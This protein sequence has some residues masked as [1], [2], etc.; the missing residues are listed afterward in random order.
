M[1]YTRSPSPN[2]SMPS[3]PSPKSQ[4]KSSVLRKSGTFPSKHCIASAIPQKNSSSKS[5]SAL[6]SPRAFFEHKEN[7]RD[8]NDSKPARTRSPAENPYKGIKG[9]MAPTISASSKIAAAA[10]RKKIL[11]EKNDDSVKIP[12]VLVEGV[13]VEEILPKSGMGFESE[14]IS[15]RNGSRMMDFS[16]SRGHNQST[17]SHH[18]SSVLV[19]E[20]K[21]E[22]ILPKS[23]MDFES[24]DISDQNRSKMIDFS[25][26]TG[27]NQSTG[28]HHPSCC[29]SDAD[30]SLPPYDP[31][32]NYLSPRPQFLHYKPKPMIEQN[33]GF[34]EDLFYV[35]DGRRLEDSFSDTEGSDVCSEYT[36]ETKASPVNM[37]P[38]DEDVSTK[39]NTQEAL[40]PYE[41]YASE[42]KTR[43]ETYKPRIYNRSFRKSKIIPFLL[44]ST[45]VLSCLPLADLPIFSPLMK[46]ESFVGPHT[47]AFGVIKNV[48]PK[49]YVAFVNR[50][51]QGLVSML[52]QWLLDFINVLSSSG[53][54]SRDESDMMFFFNMS[55]SPSIVQNV[56]LDFGYSSELETVRKK[57]TV[58][59]RNY[60]VNTMESEFELDK[61]VRNALVRND[62][63]D[64]E[65]LHF[66]LSDVN[67][68]GTRDKM[69]QEQEDYKYAKYEDLN[70][71][72]DLNSQ[73]K[74]IDVAI[75]EEA[76][77]KGYPAGFEIVQVLEE[78][79][80]V[81]LKQEN[82]HSFIDGKIKVGLPELNGAGAGDEM[83][84]KGEEDYHPKYE[85]GFSSFMVQ[86]K[87]IDIAISKEVHGDDY[88]MQFEE[89]ALMGL[90][91]E[92]I[93]LINKDHVDSSTELVVASQM[94][95]QKDDAGVVNF[96]SEVQPSVFA[97]ANLILPVLGVLAAVVLA[98]ALVFLLMK[99]KHLHATSSKKHL[100]K[101]NRSVSG[102]SVSCKD[103]TNESPYH[104]LT[105]LAEVVGD[106][107]PTEMSSCLNSSF[108]VRHQRKKIASHEVTP[109]YE[110]LQRRES[111]VSSSVSYGSFTAFEKTSAR[112][113]E[114]DDEVMTPVRRSSRIRNQAISG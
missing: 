47:Q 69:V 88:L 8:L 105:G 113:G 7:E 27:H 31:M 78:Q 91:Q 30:P 114:K 12:S 42:P 20:L 33:H 73:T 18:P 43:A 23:E 75:S 46:Y 67:G 28:N 4:E 79:I 77:G 111:G 40:V 90:R 94:K 87:K 2:P 10:P 17:G 3:N 57:E 103:F 89:Q 52:R 34:T 66:K 97:N 49:Y 60:P 44:L 76:D 110:T 80:L 19:E 108:S 9:F 98:I 112:K 58:E 1:A 11:S 107:G 55:I 102:G 84:Q 92:N 50:N 32:T 70:S 72:T 41:T 64:G 74:M 29:P 48:H 22:E 71:L 63:D 37:G 36:E 104:N 61:M 39:L 24:E 82:S 54:T 6:P 26:S 109:N 65:K 15:V 51:I 16:G 106:S 83:V 62:I 86:P 25:G 101:K 81:D 14:D 21:V 5:A 96:L 100:N 59:G 53:Y 68:D 35:G 99:Q 93:H 85:E 95:N 56:G 45:I 38:E 13:K